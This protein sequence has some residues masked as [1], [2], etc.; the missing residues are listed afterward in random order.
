MGYLLRDVFK[1][2][3]RLYH[4][5]LGLLVI[6]K[7]ED[8]RFVNCAVHILAARTAYVQVEDPFPFIFVS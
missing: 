3:I 1:A 6:K 4:S 7:K 2:H 8:R 5:T